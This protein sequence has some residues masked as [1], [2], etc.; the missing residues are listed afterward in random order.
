MRGDRLVCLGMDWMG[1]EADAVM[2]YADF[3]AA[4]GVTRTRAEFVHGEGQQQ[5]ARDVVEL[6][7]RALGWRGM[8]WQSNLVEAPQ[9]GRVF[10]A[11]SMSQI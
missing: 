1:Q 8:R 5:G 10:S 11:R 4:T 2:N 9:L 6:R 7:G 3:A